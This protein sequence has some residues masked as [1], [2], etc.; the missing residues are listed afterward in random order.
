VLSS[1]CSLSLKYQ[2]PARLGIDCR[3]SIARSLLLPLVKSREE[4]R[5]IEYLFEHQI[6]ASSWPSSRQTIRCISCMSRPP[7][8]AS[9]SFARLFVSILKA[10]QLAVLSL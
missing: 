10:T 3:R 2:Y 1:Y 6:I 9:S 4:E 5:R 8:T 7:S